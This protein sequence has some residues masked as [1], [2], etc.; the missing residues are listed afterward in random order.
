MT[1]VLLVVEGQSEEAFVNQVLAPAL[2]EQQVFLTATRITTS[3]TAHRSFKGGFVN[4]AHLERDVARLL[5][6]DSSR[7]VGC[8]VDLYRLPS[9][10]PGYQ[11]T[12]GMTDPY[13]K[14]GHLHQAWGEHFV[15]ARFIPYVQ[16]HEFESLLFADPS[17]AAEV[18]GNNGLPAA[19]LKALAQFHNNPELINQTPEGAPSKRLLSAYG[20]YEKVI[21]GVQLAQRIG[22][23]TMKSKCEHFNSWY[24]R[25]LALPPL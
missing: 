25:L 3:R 13:Q 10:A 22:L 19:M 8:M 20:G 23:S 17:A 6:A 18:T 1:R 11:Q 4:F 16:L 5:V 7:Y 21:H 9:T 15:S 24:A 2:G 12:T 14:V